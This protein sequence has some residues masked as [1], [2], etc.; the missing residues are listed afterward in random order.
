LR[1]TIKDKLGLWACPTGEIIM[2]DVKVPMGNR[3]GEE[4]SLGESSG[5][6]SPSRGMKV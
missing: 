4:G 1:T 3:L 2:G 6:S 5:I